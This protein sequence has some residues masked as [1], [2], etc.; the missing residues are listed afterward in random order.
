MK[1]LLNRTC[2]LL[3]LAQAANACAQA[4][5]P[6]ANEPGTN[7]SMTLRTYTNLIQVPV[8]VLS[9]QM[10]PLPPIAE[11]RFSVSLDGGRGF[12][13]THVRRQGDDPIDLQILIDATHP[14]S[15]FLN[16][17][18]DAMEKLVPQYI[19]PQD[20]VT[21]Y[22]LDGC[23]LRRFSPEQS[24][25][26]ML[27]KSGVQAALQ[28]IQAADRGHG[29]ATRSMLFDALKYVVTAVANKPGRRVVLLL[30]NDDDGGALVP[31]HDLLAQTGV[32]V[33]AV[34]ESGK[35]PRGAPT[36][37]SSVG[38]GGR[39]AS[40]I[41]TITRY[42]QDDLST[43]C[44]GSGGLL[45]QTTKG[46]IAPTLQ[47]FTNIVRGRYIIEFPRSDLFKSGSHAIRIDVKNTS[48][49]LRIASVSFPSAD[50]TVL[51]DPNN[52]KRA[53]RMPLPPEPVDA[54]ASP[55]APLTTPAPTAT[56]P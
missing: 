36:M 6:Q 38:T 13:P 26:S 5:V 41:Q 23:K 31:I 46:Q 22:G 28:P 45:L 47:S 53:V 29:C 3:C 7:A 27:L 39:Q 19:K 21:V 37:V 50:P 2:V 40:G 14:E 44:E 8:L 16:G 17:L 30:T 20:R 33:F 24:A 12:K 55:S 1:N 51:A 56:A 48:T 25:N 11:D 18:P 9:P 43:M 4:S 34:A 10:V 54:V 49:F 32:S 15:A 52:V 35:V 42:A